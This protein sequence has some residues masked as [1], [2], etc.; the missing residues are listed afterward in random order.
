M[1]KVGFSLTF[2]ISCPTVVTSLHIRQ[3]CGPAG[4]QYLKNDYMSVLVHL[5]LH[6]SS[7]LYIYNVK[8]TLLVNEL[9]S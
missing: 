8:G 4:I 2:A 5:L 1:A 6:L 7:S 9:R 3:A